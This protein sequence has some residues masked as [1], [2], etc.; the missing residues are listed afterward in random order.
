M[1]KLINEP[2]LKTI[3]ELAKMALT[4]DAEL[5]PIL[6]FTTTKNPDQIRIT[7]LKFDK[8][9][10]DDKAFYLALIGN[11][12][13][14]KLGDI[15]EA[16]MI[17]DAYALILAKGQK[18]NDADMPVR[19]NPARVETIVITGRTADGKNN[20][21][22]MQPYK[23]DGKNINFD[24]PTIEVNKKGSY[25]VGLLDYIFNPLLARQAERVQTSKYGKN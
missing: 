5:V 4:R 10:H 13:K 11:D 18:P 17:N 7:P 12:I 23:R 20:G 3:L 2:Q 9:D 21:L 1:T 14:T 15:Q 16:V 22:I 6:F 24:E 8:P 25:S 19:D